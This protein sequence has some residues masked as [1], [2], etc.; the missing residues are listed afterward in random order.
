MGGGIGERKG[1]IGRQIG[2]TGWGGA[3]GA[4]WHR[5][6]CEGVDRFLHVRGSGVEDRVDAGVEGVEEVI[7]EDHDHGLEHFHEFGEGDS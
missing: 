1:K 6:G 2:L 3:G 4:T 5:M 7:A